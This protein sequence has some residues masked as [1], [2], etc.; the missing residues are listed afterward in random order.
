MTYYTITEFGA[1]SSTQLEHALPNATGIQAAIDQAYDAGGGTVV[2]P[3]GCTFITAS[4]ELKSNIT[5]L[6]EPGSRL[7][8]S[9]DITHYHNRTH[10]ELFAKADFGRF[11]IWADGA[12]NLSIA[13][14]GTLDGNSP[15]FTKERRAEN[16]VALNPRAQSL[17]LF[18]CNRLRLSGFEMRNCPSWALRPCGCND[19]V[20]EGITIAS[21]IGLVNTDGIDIDC[22]K[23]VVV[24]GCIIRCG[25]DG[26]CLKTRREAAQQYGSC[27]NILVSDCIVQSSCAAIK[28]G[29]E[30]WADIRNVTVSNCIVHDSHRGLAIDGRDDSVIE[31]ISFHNITVHTK[32][33]HPVWWHEG[34]PIIMCPVPR[35]SGAQPS[36]VRNVTFSDIRIRAERGI[37]I[38]ASSAR[39]IENLVFRNI[40]LTIAKET[41]YSANKVDPRPCPPD[42]KPA[43][44][45]AKAEATQWGSLW[46][47]DC[48]H[49]FAENVNGLQIETMRIDSKLGAAADAA[50][51]PQFHNVQDLIQK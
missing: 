12:E 5:L 34:E 8:A 36:I 15:A 42:F 11:W 32:L 41:G 47:H 35:P 14:S 2:V 24:K 3:A 7:L 23:R 19:V 13:G 48:P 45:T 28:I 33:S 39:P 21:D 38:Q 9:P 26:I 29:T 43:G 10:E 50:K 51:A 6:L 49:F 44:S 16:T 25:D 27:E 20:I 22:C 37:F 1:V 18:G 30:S 46:L 31:N 4:F 17:V 40:D